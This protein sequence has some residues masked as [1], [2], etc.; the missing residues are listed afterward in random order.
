MWQKLFNVLVQFAVGV[1]TSSAFAKTVR[2]FITA[3]L[4]GLAVTHVGFLGS[5]VERL[6]DF[7][8]YGLPVL[9]TW[10][11]F[12][13]AY[14]LANAW[15]PVSEL[16]LGLTGLWTFRASLAVLKIIEHIWDAVPFQ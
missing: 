3:A 15:L 12:R 16:M 5:L 8:T 1:F 14:E 11:V 4:T 6:W 10:S 2:F 7:G 9:T 13:G